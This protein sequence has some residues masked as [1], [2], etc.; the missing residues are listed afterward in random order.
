MFKRLFIFMF[1]DTSSFSLARLMVRG[2]TWLMIGVLVGRLAMFVT[3]IAAARILGKIPLGEFGLIESTVSAFV[4][5]AGLGMVVAISKNL[6]ESFRTDPQ[7][8]GRILG[9]VYLLS[10][11]L[12]AVLLLALLLSSKSL[13]ARLSPNPDFLPSLRIGLLLSLLVPGALASAILNALQSYRH[14]AFANIIQ[15]LVS[16]PLTLVLAPLWGLNGFLL[17]FGLGLLIMFIYQGVI[18]FFQCRR[19]NIMIR[20]RGM[21][22]ELPLIWRYGLP[23][24]LSGMFIGPVT[25]ATRALLSQQ[26]GGLGELGLYMAAFSLCSVFIAVATL[27]SNVTVPVL[28]A[29]TTSAE[30]HS[31]IKRSIFLYWLAAIG[32]GLPMIALANHLVKFL[33]GSEFINAGPVMAIVSLG[34]GARV[35][36]NSFGSLLI[37]MDRVWHMTLAAIAGEPIFLGLTFFLAPLYGARGLALAYL[38]SSLVTLILLCGISAREMGWKRLPPLGLIL[39]I[40]LVGAAWL[41]QSIA[42]LWLALVSTILLLGLFVASSFYLALRYDLLGGLV[43]RVPLW[44]RSR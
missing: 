36:Y 38:I 34:I 7:R 40:V 13:A 30:K 43:G 35:I 31:G 8:A 20:L 41:I 42:S 24:M 39:T 21:A 29:S 16:L 44:V 27:L 23:S 6:A 32:L 37:V 17:A 26:E 15:G 9:M 19:H 4:G 28:S 14:V 1:D 5:F 33:L 3:R 25:L 11:I 18:I 22:Q 10:G 12:F 2:L